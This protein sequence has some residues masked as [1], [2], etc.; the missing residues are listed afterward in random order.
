MRGDVYLQRTVS[1]AEAEGATGGGV[2][3]HEGWKAPPENSH[4]DFIRAT[5]RMTSFFGKTWPQNNVPYSS[6]HIAADVTFFTSP[7]TA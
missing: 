3:L 5:M 6:I 1:V 2:S 4:P 7:L